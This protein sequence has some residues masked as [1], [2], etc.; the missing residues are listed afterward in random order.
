MFFNVIPLFKYPEN[1]FITYQAINL[2]SEIIEN[3][4]EYGEDY[5]YYTI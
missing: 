3:G 5:K 1:K 2:L 4:G